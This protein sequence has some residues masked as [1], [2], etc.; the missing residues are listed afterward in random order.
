MF[1]KRSFKKINNKFIEYIN[2]RKPVQKYKAKHLFIFTST[3]Y[4]LSTLFDIGISYTVFKYEQDFFINNEFSK[5]IIKAFLGDIL[6][7]FIAISLISVLFIILYNAYKKYNNM[8]TI[9]SYKA[10]ERFFY[11]YFVSGLIYFGSILHI[12]GGLSWL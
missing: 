6:S 8:T 7:I 11:F 12:V 5:V 2:K 10:K 9:Y 1:S 4:I 3:F